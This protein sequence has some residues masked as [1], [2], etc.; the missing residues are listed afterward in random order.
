MRDVELS[1]GVVT[2]S[3]LRLD[4]VDAHLAG[5]D[6]KLVRRLSGGPGTRAG[7]E[8][9]VVHCM[10]QWAADGPLRAFGI[11]AGDGKVLAGTIDLRFDMAG[12]APGQVN[13]AYDL[14][15]AWRGKGL[16]TRRRPGP[17]L[18]GGRR[19][20]A[21]SDQGGPGERGVGGGRAAGGLHLCETSAG[22]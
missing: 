20:D 10:E 15:P 22:G 3:P 8:K 21:G 5:E 12:L 9:Y 14:Y 16:A 13:I 17:R 6:E 4:D 2:L 11:R 1:D 7:V 19:C 18:R